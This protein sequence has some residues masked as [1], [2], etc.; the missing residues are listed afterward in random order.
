MSYGLQPELYNTPFPTGSLMLECAIEKLLR[1]KEN[2]H[3]YSLDTANRIQYIE[4]KKPKYKEIDTEIKQTEKPMIKQEAIQPKQ[5][6]QQPKQ[7]QQY[8]QQQQI[9]K[10]PQSTRIPFNGY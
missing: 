10:E 3:L 9:K 1:D 8:Q 6:Q 2:D 4:T 7:Q 5:Q